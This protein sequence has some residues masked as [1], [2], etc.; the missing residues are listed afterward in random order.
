MH[1]L[2]RLLPL[3]ALALL[4][5]SCTRPPVPVA[6]FRNTGVQMWSNAVTDPMALQGRWTQ[7]A[8]FASD[9]TP[10]CATGGLDLNPVANGLYAAARLCVNGVNTVYR[11]PLAIS[12]PGR[13]RPMDQAQAP[14][15]RDWWVL[16]VDVD[17]R[18]LVLGTPDGS[19]AVILNRDARLPGDRRKAAREILEWNG[20]DLS[21][22]QT[23]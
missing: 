16:W 20:Y 18:T 11:G 10:E 17:I 14:L 6:Q 3:A 12:G 7:V 19:F 21:H 5:S 8:T 15:N 13:L 23:F 1:R 4:V 9:G 2:I 22:L